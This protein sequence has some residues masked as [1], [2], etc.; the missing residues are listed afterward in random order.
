MS[1]AWVV[2]SQLR[3]LP[4]VALCLW[5]AAAACQRPEPPEDEA[6]QQPAV[7]LPDPFEP[8]AL[9]RFDP[10]AV[11]LRA[12]LSVSGEFAHNPHEEVACET[13]HQRVPGHSTHGDVACT[14]CHPAPTALEAG[15][16]GEEE[17][18]RCHHVEQTVRDCESCH[19]P[20]DFSPLSVSQRLGLAVWDEPRERSLP[21]DH[22]EHTEF[23]CA[24][25]HGADARQ[26]LV[27][28]CASCHEEHHGAAA[29]CANCHLDFPLDTH[30]AS[31]HRGCGGTGC[32]ED[33][34]RP[35]PESRARCLAC[36]VEQEDHEPGEDCSPCHLLEDITPLAPAGA[37][38]AL[39]W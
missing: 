38:G 20:G 17:C 13:C 36:H 28:E 10:R 5:L 11:A 37:G 34:S 23:D 24:Q 4:I 25:C 16:V 31:S 39:P 32:H 33:P 9:A 27:T 6:P 12:D 30:E 1:A 3:G 19:G 21:F 35:V 2:R 26:T 8:G 14:D 29:R 22:A 15:T 7:E 18:L